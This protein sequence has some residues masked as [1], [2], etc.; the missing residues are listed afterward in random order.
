MLFA[1]GFNDFYQPDSPKDLSALKHSRHSYGA[2]VLSVC[3]TRGA[4]LRDVK[5]P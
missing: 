4:C 5:G 2:Q 3:F 1:S